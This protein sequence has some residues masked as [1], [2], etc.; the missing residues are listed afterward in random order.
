MSME[1]KLRDLIMS[2]T[3]NLGN[4]DEKNVKIKFDLD[5]DLP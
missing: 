4:Y 5:D 1:K 3:S 2:I